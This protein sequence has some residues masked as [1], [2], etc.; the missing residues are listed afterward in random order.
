MFCGPIHIR[1]PHDPH[2]T[3]HA[4]IEAAGEM[5]F[6]ILDD[7][8]GPMRVGA[9][10]VNM[11]IARDGTRVSAARAFLHPNLSRANLALLLSTHANSNGGYLG[12][13]R[14]EPVFEELERRGAVVFVHPTASPDSS[15]RQLGLPDSLIDFTA[16]TT[17]A[18]AQTQ[19]HYTRFAR[20]PS[21]KYILS[22]AGGTVEGAAL[23]QG[24]CTQPGTSLFRERLWRLQLL[25]AALQSCWRRRWLNRKIEA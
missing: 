22:H 16:D 1:R 19:M 6:P 4:V 23:W 21:V 17:R 25:R 15:A 13:A 12:D 18:V 5:G 20:T 24:I 7:M 10:Y 11:N 14:F 8:N 2:P 9:G 3:A